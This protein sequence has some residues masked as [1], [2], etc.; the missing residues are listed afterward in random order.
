MN[1]NKTQELQNLI[2]SKRRLSLWEVVISVLAITCIGYVSLV[3]THLVLLCVGL[4]I[5]ICGIWVAV[6][7]S[8]VSKKIDS[9]TSES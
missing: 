2:T 6:V 9:L 4:V 1:T 8:N 3:S 5:S 7:K